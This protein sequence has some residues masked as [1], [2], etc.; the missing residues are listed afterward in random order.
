MA[1][2]VYGM[3][4]RYLEHIDEIGNYFVLHLVEEFGQNWTKY[5]DGVHCSTIDGEHKFILLVDLDSEGYLYIA[6]YCREAE[7]RDKYIRVSPKSNKAAFQKLRTELPL[8]KDEEDCFYL[9][10]V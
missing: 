8:L 10:K 6:S 4:V 7:E 5:A 9:I 1:C 3:R 2:L